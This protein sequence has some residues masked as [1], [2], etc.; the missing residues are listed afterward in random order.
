LSGL[1]PGVPGQTAATDDEGRFEFR[2]VPAG[3][4]R[5]EVQ[6]AGFLRA[7]YGA[8]RPNRAGTPVPVAE[9]SRTDGLT[10]RL[11]HGAAISGTVRDARGRPMPGIT[12]SALRRDYSALGERRLSSQASATT[13]DQGAYRAWGLPPGDYVIAATPSV[14]GGFGAFPSNDFTLLTTA[15]VD[16]AL[17]GGSPLSAVPPQ[18]VPTHSYAPVFAPGTSDVSLATP[19]RISAAEDREGVDVAVSLVRTARLDVVTTRDGQPAG[20]ARITLAGAGD[21][22]DLL[23]GNAWWRPRTATADKQ[24]RFTFFD[25]PPGTYRLVALLTAPPNPPAG[26][27]G[28]SGATWAMAEVTVNGTD[29]DVSLAMQPAMTITG[30]IVFNGSS[31]PPDD[32]TLL[33]IRLLPPG[34]GSNV[35]SGPSGGNVDADRSFSFVGVTPGDYRILTIMRSRWRGDWSLRSATVNGR[36]VLDGPLRIGAGDQTELVLAYTDRPTDVSGQF[37]DSTGRPA[38]DYFIVMFPA[39][40]ALWVPGS[41]RILSTRPGSDGQYSMRGLPPGDYLLAALSDLDSED[42][43]TPSFFD[44][45]TPFATKVTLAEGQS[46]RQDLTVRRERPSR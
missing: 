27:A 36:D 39:D 4:Y 35:G 7:S 2:N 15:D 45:L 12:V 31:P 18:A 22:A 32:P 26:S 17:Q 24:G 37:A 14:P 46:I 3:R 5:I 21:A 34:S 1:D 43:F 16:R 25:L 40:R 38:P 20:S 8:T 28:E 11:V 41:R 9:G 19:L 33:N 10:I 30:R 29:I 42:L 23:V 6:K 44:Q 13:D